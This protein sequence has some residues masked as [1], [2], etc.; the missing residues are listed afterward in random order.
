MIK[1]ILFTISYIS[2]FVLPVKLVRKLLNGFSQISSYRFLILIRN[3]RFSFSPNFFIC[4]PFK[5]LGYK[6]IT[7]GKNFSAGRGFRI[8]CWENYCGYKYTP[9]IIIGDNVSIGWRCHIGAINHIYIGN[10]VLIGSNVLIIDHSHGTWGEDLEISPINRPLESKGK[11]I[12]EDNVWIA[13]GVCILPNVHIGHNSII[14]SNAVVLN[15]IPPYSLA[16]G[17]PAKVV[18]IHN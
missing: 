9:S 14:G 10:N 4:N 8:E 5:I 3:K 18:K 12:I 15:D 11:I 13:D 7:I 2:L 1:K 6:Y 16:V 17:V